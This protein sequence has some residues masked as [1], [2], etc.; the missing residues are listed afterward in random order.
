MAYLLECQVCNHRVE[1]TD[2]AAVGVDCSECG[3]F[4]SLRPVKVRPRLELRSLAER[5]V[6]LPPAPA[7]T[8]PAV[9]P[10][11]PPPSIVTSRPVGGSGAA[12]E[13]V[14]PS[15]IVPPVGRP[16]PALPA[17]VVP[18][19]PTA[20]VRRIQPIARAEYEPPEPS[21]ILTAAGPAAMLLAATGLVCAFVGS[22]SGWA[23]PLFALGLLVGL[24]GTIVDDGAERSRHLPA[25]AGASCSV[26]LVLSLFTD[27]ASAVRF[28]RSGS[29]VDP[30][31]VR[32]VPLSGD[33]V[34]PDVDDDGW[35]DAGRAALQRGNV[36]VRVVSATLTP[37]A[38]TAGPTA[39]PTLVVR[40]Q[41]RRVWGG[42]QVLKEMP[43]PEGL[44]PADAPQA[45]LTDDA[46]RAY[47][48]VP[49]GVTEAGGPGDT[50]TYTFEAPAAGYRFLR[51]ELRSANAGGFKFKIP[52]AVVSSEPVKGNRPTGRIGR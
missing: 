46:G 44:S 35:V 19:K 7:R 50:P 17:A 9:A 32:V 27:L 43:E 33:A 8:I 23:I 36:G 52:N 16:V 12:A 21:P 13:H 28:G 41:V 2:P 10:P 45:T 15:A 39:G 29:A 47:R 3:S 20:P 37:A 34:D 42:E 38:A 4:Y 31:L 5:P 25:V 6:A 14:A 40:L 1:V 49:I 11:E 51:L 48:P 30:T 24:L 18:A 22:L 26:L